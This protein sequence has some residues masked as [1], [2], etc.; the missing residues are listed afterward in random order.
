[1]RYLNCQSVRWLPLCVG[2]GVALGVALNQL[3]VFTA[4]GA[5]LGTLLDRPWRAKA[6]NVRNHTHP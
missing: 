3:A 4:M 6:C 2:M 1:M 5:A